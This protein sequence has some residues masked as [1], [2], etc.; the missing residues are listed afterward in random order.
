[1]VGH[2]LLYHPAITKLKEMISEGII[3]KIQYIYSNRLNLG[4]VRK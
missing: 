2:V 4:S 1:M 3:G